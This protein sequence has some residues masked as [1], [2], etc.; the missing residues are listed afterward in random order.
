MTKLILVL[1]AALLF[2]SFATNLAPTRQNVETVEAKKHDQKQGKNN[3]KKDRKDRRDKREKRQ[4]KREKKRDRREVRAF[5]YIN[6][7]TGLATFNPDVNANSECETPDQSDTQNLSP[8]GTVTN[9]VHNDACLFRNGVAVDTQVSFEISGVGTFSACPDP[10]G[11]GPK[12]GAILQGG[13]R[14][15]LSGYQTTGMA[16]DM[17]Y[18]ARIN[19]TDQPGTT[20]V[21]FCADADNNGCTDEKVKNQIQVLWQP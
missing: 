14:C 7:D 5:S 15:S 2:G 16:G 21:M 9:N 12:T 8:M 4:D 17:E 18:H 20:T 6:P 1:A 13:K 3:N 10:D 19:N 11:A